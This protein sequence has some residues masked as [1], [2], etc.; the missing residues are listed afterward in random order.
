MEKRVKCPPLI[1]IPLCLCGNIWTIQT[2]H[3]ILRQRAVAH[4]V[5]C[6]VGGDVVHGDADSLIHVLV[7]EDMV[8]V[9]GEE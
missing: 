5:R 3:S 9:T 7:V 4:S 1:H 6:L 2:Q 8:T